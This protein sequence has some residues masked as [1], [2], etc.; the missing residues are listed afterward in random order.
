MRVLYALHGYKPAYKLGGPIHAVSALAERLVQKGHEVIVFASNLNLDEDLDVPTNQRID[1]NGVQVWYFKHE[2]P[3]QRWLPFVPYLANSIGYLYAPGMRAELDRIVPSVDLVHIQNP[4]IYPTYAAG[5]AA[6][7]HQKP[8]FYQQRGALGPE[9]LKYRGLKKKLY[10]RAIERPLMERAITLIALTEAEVEAYASLGVR[11][12]CRIIPNGVDIGNSPEPLGTSFGPFDISPNELVILFLAR[13][14]P[15]KGAHR[16]IQAF[17]RIHTHHPTAKLVMAGPDDSR[18]VEKFRDEIEKAGLG[19]RILFPGMVTGETKRK[20]LARADLFCLPS[21]AEGFSV[22]VLEAM[23]SKTPVLISPECHFA[24]VESAFAGKVVSTSVD[25]LTDAL[26]SLLG[27]SASLKEMGQNAYDL[28]KNEYDW[29]Q[30]VESLISVYAEGISRK[31][32]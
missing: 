1:V 8:L 22:A 14:H 6:I 17:L 15:M 10:I 16:L 29:D 18:T 4:F 20:L 31:Q 7:R 24:T 32:G 25:D 21:A 19:N 11:T 23:A 5:K 30:I 26:S 13:L 12:P 3:I 9:H 27:D 2:E 28:V